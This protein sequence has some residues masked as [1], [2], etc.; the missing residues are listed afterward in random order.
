MKQTFGEKLKELFSNRL[1]PVGLVFI[2]AFVIVCIQI[3]N[4]QMVDPEQTKI[5]HDEKSYT[6]VISLPSTRGNIYDRKGSLLAYNEL[7]YN[8]DMFNS[9]ELKN[10]EEMNRAI[11]ELIQIMREFNYQREFSFPIKMDEDGSLYFTI[12]GNALYRFKKNAYGLKNVSDLKPEHYA[13]SAEDVFKF[14]RFGNAGTRMFQIS[15]EYSKKDALEIMAYRYQFFTLYPSYSSFRVKSD[16]SDEARI[17]FYE[18]TTTIP[19]IEITKSSKRVYLDSEYFSHIIGYVGLIN[20]EELETLR[21]S[22][23][24][25]K[26]VD[27]SI[28]GK[29]GIEKSYEMYLSGTDGE[30]TILINDRGQVRTKT[31]TKE[32][33]PGND[34]Y[35]TIDREQQIAC[36]YIIERHVAGILLA[37]I[38]KGKDDYGSKGKDATN[39]TIPIYDVYY[40]LFSNHII[41]T[42]HFASENASRIEK[43]MF[44]L[45]QTNENI[46]WNN[47]QK[48]LE[49]DCTLCKNKGVSAYI[50]DYVD[51]MYQKLSTSTIGWG[52]INN[53]AINTR[54]QEYIDYINGDTSLSHF[55]QYAIT[56]GW[57]NLDRLNIGTE[58]Y[59]TKELYGYLR[60]YIVNHFRNDADY[61][62]KIYKTLISED[63]ISLR[64]ISLALFDQG[65]LSPDLDTYEKLANNELDPYDFMVH[66]IQTLEITPAM[67][68][69]EPCSGT[70]I[71]TDPNSGT[72]SCMASYPSYDN[73]M[74]TNKVDMAYYNRLLQDKSSPLVFRATSSKTTTGSTFKPLASIMGL[75]EGAITVDEKIEDKGKFLEVDPSPKCW[76]YPSRHGK[77]TVSEAIRDSCNY[78]FFTVGYRLSI[79]QRGEYVDALGIKTIQ[80][81]AKMFGFGDK[82]GVELSEPMPV[83]SNRD[84]VRTSI[85]YYHSFSPIQIARYIT[86]IA[87]EGTCYNLTLVN[88]VV[89]QT[90]EV[91]LSNIATVLNSLDDVPEEYWKAVKVGMYDVVNARGSSLRKYYYNL[92]VSVAGKTGTAQVSL[93]YP[94]NALFLSFAPSEDPEVCVTVVIPNGYASNNAAVVARE[95]YAYLFMDENREALLSGNVFAA[96]IESVGYTD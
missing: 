49:P 59:D 79:N 20:G 61:K 66:K 51:F 12:T 90:G 57:I 78:F 62:S 86:T 27:S 26:Y 13:A 85:G 53:A 94:N 24:K 28:V 17:R 43:N 91:L 48:L 54:D 23:S 34:V 74:L 68:A 50:Q 60:D 3:F 80:K 40:A 47:Y 88:R 84:A 6:K 83:I 14:M 22:A 11:F 69:L 18:S 73:N 56:Q 65:V 70:I 5:T 10:N 41:D 8:L 16:I 35:L 77:I 72:V 87:N 93:N 44:S 31:I 42:E 76:A 45:F 29:N 4:L 67:L 52:I 64:D 81:Y 58:Y 30:A 63:A 21:G 55:L 39:I 89:G 33:V 1:V 71:I 82:S 92:D 2:V 25:T 19:G 95:V 36:Y 7:Q 15:E 32:P 37:A 96:K 75:M 46:I 38:V 9:A